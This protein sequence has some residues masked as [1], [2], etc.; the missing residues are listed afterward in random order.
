M[1]VFLVCFFLVSKEIYIVIRGG[2]YHLEGAKSI[3]NILFWYHIQG[4][5]KIAW[6]LTVWN[7]ESMSHLLLPSA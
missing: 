7:T 4:W 2:A 1:P 5:T 6:L 3:R